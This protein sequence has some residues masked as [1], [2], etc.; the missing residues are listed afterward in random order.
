MKK[1]FALLVVVFGLVLACG[2]GKGNNPPKIEVEGRLTYTEYM[3]KED[4]EAVVVIQ[5]EVC[6]DF[7]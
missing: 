4:D 5:I 1:L 2:C 6:L 7:K 3:A